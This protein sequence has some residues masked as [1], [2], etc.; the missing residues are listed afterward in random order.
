MRGHEREEKLMGY[1]EPGRGPVMDP[2]RK[3]TEE[4]YSP[5][6]MATGDVVLPRNTSKPAQLRG[7][8]KESRWNTWKF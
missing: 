4:A 8:R 5:N 1:N 6:C 2:P 7:A 3:A